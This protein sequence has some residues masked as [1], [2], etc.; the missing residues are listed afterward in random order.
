MPME[1]EEMLDCV[2]G[3]KLRVKPSPPIVGVL[4]EEQLIRLDISSVVPASFGIVTAF[5]LSTLIYAE[6]LCNIEALWVLKSITV[7]TVSEPYTS[8]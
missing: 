4:R 6:P 5:W 2:S 1:S 8:D 3:H 7:E